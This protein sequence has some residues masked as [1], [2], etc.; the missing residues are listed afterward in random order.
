MKNTRIEYTGDKINT[1]VL[2]CMDWG[3]E[4]GGVVEREE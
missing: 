1:L 3:A 4:E 2:S